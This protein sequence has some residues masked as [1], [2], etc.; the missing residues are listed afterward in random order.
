MPAAL[1]AS[2]EHVP[3]DVL[4][5]ILALHHQICAGLEEEPPDVEPMF[6][7]TK[8]GHIIAMDW[9]EGFMLAVS[10]RPRAWLRLT[11][12]GSHGQLITPILCHLIDDDGNSVLGIPQDKLAKTLDE[13]AN[14]IPATVIGIFRFWRAQT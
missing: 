2:P 4:D 9:C 6:W 8:D 7:E 5:A 11:E 10:M 12:S 3:K 14:A 1:G 13:A